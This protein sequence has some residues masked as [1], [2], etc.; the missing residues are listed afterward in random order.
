MLTA[1]NSCPQLQTM[2]EFISWDMHRITHKP[3]KNHLA[4]L[5]YLE[6]GLYLLLMKS[7]CFPVSREKTAHS[8]PQL[9]R[10]KL[11]HTGFP[12]NNKPP[13]VPSP[14]NVTQP[15]RLHVVR[16]V[17]SLFERWRITRR[18]MTWRE[19]IRWTVMWL[20]Q[21]KPLPRVSSC[22]LVT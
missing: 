18:N 19:S 1:M 8:I 3:I 11:R 21:H 17:L 16:K 20:H 9:S 14:T 2:G 22:L 4:V 15:W 7:W 5:T 13:A 10:L 6:D 12:D